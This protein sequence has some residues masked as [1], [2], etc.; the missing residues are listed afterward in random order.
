MSTTIRPEISMKNTYWI[1]RHRYYELKHFCLQYPAWKK[2]YNS[3][4]GLSSRRDVD[5]VSRNKYQTSNPTEHSSM[6]RAMYAERMRLVE[7]AAEESDSDIFN[8]L[9]LAVTKGVSYENLK[10]MYDIPCCREKY[11][12]SYRKFFWILNQKRG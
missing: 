3:L 11:Y 9:I 4:L 12:E 10:T 1:E 8:Y 7:D 6:I 2:A 5:N